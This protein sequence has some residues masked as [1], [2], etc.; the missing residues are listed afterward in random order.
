MRLVHPP[1]CFPGPHIGWRAENLRKTV[2]K[3][4]CLALVVME[5]KVAN[6]ASEFSQASRKE[7]DVPLSNAPSGS[8]ELRAESIASRALTLWLSAEGRK[9]GCFPATKFPIEKRNA[10]SWCF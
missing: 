6:G 2:T 4:A 5:I 10:S 9:A 3:W 7:P 1:R 8:S